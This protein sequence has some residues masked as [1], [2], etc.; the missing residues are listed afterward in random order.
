MYSVFYKSICN[1]IPTE[2]VVARLVGN[3]DA[4]LPVASLAAMGS[5]GNIS[6][7]LLNDTICY[8]PAHIVLAD[9]NEKIFTKYV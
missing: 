3:T 7:I 6:N 5:L 2:V 1:A 4:R 8:T 9:L